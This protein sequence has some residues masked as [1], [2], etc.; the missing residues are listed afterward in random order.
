MGSKIRIERLEGREMK[1][2]VNPTDVVV[3]VRGIRDSHNIHY[4]KEDY[5]VAVITGTYTI[6]DS[7]GFVYDC[8]LNA[9][10]RIQSPDV[11]ISGSRNPKFYL[12]EHK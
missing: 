12:D 3:F 9:G 6:K 2:I 4:P 8:H 10:E 11:M 1:V 7:K 5:C